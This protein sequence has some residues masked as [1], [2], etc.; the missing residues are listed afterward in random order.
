MIEVKLVLV[1]A[2][3]RLVVIRR[4]RDGL[5]TCRG[6]VDETILHDEISGQRGGKRTA[7]MVR[8]RG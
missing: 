5:W 1:E 8:R 6:R 7:G 2:R 4:W 3:H